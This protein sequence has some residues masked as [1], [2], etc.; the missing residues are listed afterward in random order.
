MSK[1]GLYFV[2]RSGRF[3]S[4]GKRRHENY[5]KMYT[6]DYTGWLRVSFERVLIYPD[7]SFKITESQKTAIFDYFNENERLDFYEDFIEMHENNF[8]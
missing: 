1:L 8:D 4:V 6:Y 5:I 2:D 7:D 3:Y